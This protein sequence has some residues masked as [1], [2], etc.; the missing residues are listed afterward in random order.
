MRLLFC[1]DTGVQRPAY[2]SQIASGGNDRESYWTL[3][4]V[5]LLKSSLMLLVTYFVVY[6]AAYFLIMQNQAG[7]CT[8]RRTEI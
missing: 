5:Y 7:R 3:Q 1:K 2:G 4:A 6:D 8:M